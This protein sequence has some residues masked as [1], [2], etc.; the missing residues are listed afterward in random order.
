M[1]T[2]RT[3]CLRLGLSLVLSWAVAG[4]ASAQPP[5]SL[6]MRVLDR[7]TREPVVGAIVRLRDS[8]TT[9]GADGRAVF[10]FA[11]TGRHPVVIRAVGFES[12]SVELGVG[13]PGAPPEHEVG[14]HFT[15][16]DL[17]ELVVEARRRRVIGRLV[18]FETRMAR[19]VGLFLTAVDIEARRQFNLGAILGT[20]RGVNARCSAVECVVRMSRAP[21]NCAPKYYIDGIPSDMSA[22][23][24]PI[25][26]IYGVEVY[27]GPSETP[28]EFLTA[29]AGCGV[30]SIWTKSA[31][32]SPGSRDASGKREEVRG[33]R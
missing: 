9:T 30:I 14:M 1:L 19:G 20:L 11:G 10:P 28:V 25:S 23:D 2:L 6:R 5:G 16:T 21:R 29:E 8:T 12:T 18:E 27:R 13:V 22:S 31:A 24:T 7:E 26:D 17:P 33:E 3:G 32:R 4:A 15:G